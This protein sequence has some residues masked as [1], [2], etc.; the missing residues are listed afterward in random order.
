M[1][2]KVRV[3]MC[4]Y[5]YVIIH[6]FAVCAHTLTLCICVCTHHKCVFMHVCACTKSRRVTLR[7]F[8][9]GI[10]T[11]TSRALLVE[12]VAAATVG[13]VLLARVGTLGVDARLPHGARGADT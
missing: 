12:V 4:A 2:M 11:D 5:M 9:G 7:L 10:P 3:F 8:S 1:H 13:H 6:M